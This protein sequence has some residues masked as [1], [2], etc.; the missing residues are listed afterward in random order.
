MSAVAFENFETR[1]RAQVF[2]EDCYSGVLCF[3]RQFWRYFCLIFVLVGLLWSVGVGI[4]AGLV[5]GWLPSEG[6]F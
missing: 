3:S 2:S 4:S 1:L 6:W 5:T